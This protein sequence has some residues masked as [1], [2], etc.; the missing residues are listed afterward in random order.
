LTS[1]PPG[2]SGTQ[3]EYHLHV[4]TLPREFTVGDARRWRRLPGVVLAEVDYAPGASISETHHH[5][6]FVLLVRGRL[7]SNEGVPVSRL[8][9]VP[10][11]RRYE[12]QVAEAGARCLIV[13][14]EASWLTRVRE[15]AA[16]FTRS[17]S[18]QGGFI[19]H[20]AHR[21]H[22]EFGCRD[23]VSRLAMES[24]VLGVVAEA[25]R[26]ATPLVQ[27]QPP[28]WLEHA[29]LFIDRHFAETLTLA[30]LASLAGV[31]PVHLARTF[32]RVYR[33]TVGDYLRTVRVEFARVQLLSSDASLGR[34]A[35]AAGFYDQ[36]HFCR[37]F[38][39]SIGV[40]PAAYR[41]AARAR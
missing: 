26:Q 1:R 14:I 10:A 21:L 7:T 41:L 34:I 17:R 28:A 38:K 24:L 9:F 15:D 12:F 32:R 2:F 6:R 30:M 8:T 25:A 35:A 4:F 36:S 11:H 39:L 20:L 16:L 22:A 33:T 13:D 37:V 27:P 23:E 31:H 5:A 19:L 18:F 40:S 3:A 29:R